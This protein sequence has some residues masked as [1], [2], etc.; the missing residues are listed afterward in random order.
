MDL[1]LD[2]LQIWATVSDLLTTTTEPTTALTEL[3]SLFVPGAAD[4]AVVDVVTGPDQLSRKA[5]LHQDPDKVAAATQERTLPRLPARSSSP[6]VRAVRDLEVVV[7]DEFGGPCAADSDLD[8]E[9]RR[10]FAE[11]GAAHALVVPLV[12]RGEAVGAFTLVRTGGQGFGDEEIRL[13][14]GVARRTALALSNSQ[15]YAQQHDTAVAFQRALLPALPQPEG[16]TL[17]ARYSPARPGSGVGGDWY[18]AFVGPEGRP[19]LAIGDVVGHDQYATA[20]MAELRNLLR[21]CSWHALPSP[22]V[23][24]DRLNEVVRALDL[25]TMASVLCARVD[26]HGSDYTLEWA[27]AGH[28]P[29]LV[30]GPNGG[31]R[32]LTTDPGVLIGVTD[33]AYTAAT[34][35]IPAGSR[36]VLYTD[37]LI[38]HRGDLADG[39]HRLVEQADAL[40]GTDPDYF[41]D[42]LLARLGEPNDDDVAVLVVDFAGAGH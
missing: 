29:P 10:L 24:L 39:L 19:I 41:C 15:L 38:E 40:A 33:V 18:D 42:K 30:V 17:T 2:R 28:L 20:R 26:R 14:E 34:A 16:L 22:A 23:T 7:V 1:E 21:G 32:L 9:Q 12:A 5:V 31:A 37:G 11:L 25:P 13:V 36:L 35:S 3:A 6:L 27:S 8:R 4:W